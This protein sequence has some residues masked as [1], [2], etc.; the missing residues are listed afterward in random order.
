MYR[1]NVIY[2]LGTRLKSLLPCFHKAHHENLIW[3]VVGI[4]YARRV[5]LPAAAGQAPGKKIQ[6]ESRVQRFERLLQCPKFVP[7]EVLRPVVTK[8][9]RAQHRRQPP[10]VILMD[11]SMIN[12]RLN[13]LHVALAYGGRALPLGWVRVPHDGNSDLALQQTLLRWVQSCLPPGARPTLL[14]DRE[15]HSIHLAQWVGEEL[16]WDFVLRMKAGTFVECDG[17]WLKAGDLVERGRT[18]WCGSGKV[19]KDRRATYRVKL[20]THWAADEPEPWLLLTNLGQAKVAVARYAQRFWI[21][22]MFSDHKSRG[23]NLEAT[24][25][26]DPDRLERLLVA[27]TLAY[28]WIMEVGVLVVVTDRWRYV[29]NRGAHRS[30]SLCQIGLAWLDECQ[31]EDVSPPL[32]TM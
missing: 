16:G 8:V 30:V 6:R 17:S 19:T 20:V 5:N 32:F 26:T 2:Q 23:L 22:E 13:L 28:L 1:R 11:R 3:L 7:L 25:L 15:F 14:A 4:V 24:R 27:V 12:D 18:A 21:E 9:L 31:H 10:L 29:D